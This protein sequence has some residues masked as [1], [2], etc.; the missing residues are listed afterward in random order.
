MTD[1]TELKPW[2]E[3]S[4]RTWKHGHASSYLGETPEYRSWAAM[5]AR[6]KYID[7][8]KDNKHVGRGITVCKKWQESFEVFL[9][10]MG[11]RPNGMTLDRTD[12]DGNYEPNNCRW[13]TPVE[14]ARNR[15]NAKMTF[16][17]AVDVAVRYLSGETAKALSIEFKCSESLPREIAKGRTWKDAHKVALSQ[18]G[19]NHGK[20]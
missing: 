5:R 1:T 3:R 7:R 8:D 4:G 11:P 6:C 10:D 17:R 20:S 13:A 15:R 2:S 18:M 9:A 19:G 16:D 14:Q 12:N